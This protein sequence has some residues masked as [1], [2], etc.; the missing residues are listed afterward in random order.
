MFALIIFIA[1]DGHKTTFNYTAHVR[2]SIVLNCPIHS[3]PEA[4]ITWQFSN[5]SYIN[6]A[7]QT[8]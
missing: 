7:K 1:L 6:F 8:R 2:E 5:S 3:V 4:N